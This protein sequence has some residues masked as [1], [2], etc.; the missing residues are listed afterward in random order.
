MSA[1][2]ESSA[3]AVS[4][5]DFIRSAKSYLHDLKEG[6]QNRF[7]VMKNN[8]PEAVMLSVETFEL[9]MNELD[10]MR[11]ELLA[12]ERLQNLDS[13]KLVSHEDMMR[14]FNL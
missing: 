6:T 9:M 7:V 13:N 14:K 5:T 8:Q 1:L 12:A 10:D 3:Q 4:I 11:I 2:L